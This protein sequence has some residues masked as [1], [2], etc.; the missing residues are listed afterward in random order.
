M[1]NVPLIRAA[2]F[3]SLVYD[4]INIHTALNP[5]LQCAFDRRAVN[6]KPEESQGRMISIIGDGWPDTMDSKQ[7][8]IVSHAWGPLG[9]MLRPQS[10]RGYLLLRQPL[11]SSHHNS[12]VTYIT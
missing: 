2:S 9:S 3:F 1:T 7:E 11:V 10:S 5:L 12:S 4:F 8:E 6:G